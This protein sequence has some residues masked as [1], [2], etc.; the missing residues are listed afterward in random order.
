MTQT[1]IRSQLAVDEPLAMAAGYQFDRADRRYIDD[2]VRGCEQH[3][4]ESL[5]SG[6][7]ATWFRVAPEQETGLAVGDVAC[8]AAQSATRSR[9][10]VLATSANLSAAGG[11]AGVV[12]VAASAGAYVLVAVGGILSAGVTGLGPQPGA[13]RVSSTGRCER[14]ASLAAGD[15]PIGMADAAGNLL[16]ATTKP[17]I[18]LPSGADYQHLEYRDGAWA[19]QSDL[20]LPGGHRTIRVEG[21]LGG[22]L[23]LIADNNYFGDG[24]SIMLI[25]GAGTTGG[26]EI[27]LCDGTMTPVI[28]VGSVEGTWGI[29]VTPTATST[30]EYSYIGDSTVG[31][32]GAVLYALLHALHDKGIIVAQERP[33]I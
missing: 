26:G 22:G 4:V 17:L 12:L 1:K 27:Q 13:V 5:L 15:Y 20:T 14:V 18:S 24:G 6:V 28:R 33:Q 7:I 31:D 2:Q 23:S 30:I 32:T 11:A 29:N 25:P 21:N 16:V 9:D 10:V 3:L 19:A 8:A